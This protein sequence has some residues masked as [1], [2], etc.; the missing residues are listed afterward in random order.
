MKRLFLVVLAVA[1]VSS[2]AFAE[3][4]PKAG[5]F[6]LQG[7]FTLTSVGLG[8]TFDVGLKYLITDS[9]ALRAALG[10]A[11]VS[12]TGGSTTYYDLGAGLEYHFGGKGGVSPYAG[13]EVSYSGLS[14]STGGSTPSDFAFAAMFGGEYFFSSN[15]SWAGEARLGFDSAKTAGGA[16]TTTIG[17]IG[18]G[19]FLTWY[20]N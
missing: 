6:G 12:A 1:L 9:V 2:L 4:A 8:S 7:A 20:L 15:F 19:S 14:F 11:N 3:G 16:T 10:L 17:T 13:V 5:E 18:V